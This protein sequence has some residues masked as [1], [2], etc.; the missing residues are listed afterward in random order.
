M[1]GAAEDGTVALVS[2]SLGDWGTI[3]LVRHDSEIMTVYGRLGEVAVSKGQ[4]I[5][6]GQA[7]GTVA[8]GDPPMLHFE[9]RRGAFSENPETYF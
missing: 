3:V 6:R 2:T 1:A 8:D 4:Q 5:A 9:V 7:I